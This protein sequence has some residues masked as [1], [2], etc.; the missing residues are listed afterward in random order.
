MNVLSE[1]IC[2]GHSIASDGEYIMI[3]DSD[4]HKLRLYYPSNDSED[5]VLIDELDIEDRPHY[6]QYYK[7]CFFILGSYSG[8]IYEVRVFNGK[9]SLIDTHIIDRSISYARSFSIV[10]N[11]IFIPT[12]DG[13]IYEIDLNSWR[14]K[15]V[16]YVPDDIGGMNFIDRIGDYFYLTV[17]SGKDFDMNC[18]SKILR[19]KKIEDFENNTYEDITNVLSISGTPYFIT[20]FD[21]LYYLTEIDSNQGIIEFS[22]DNQGEIKDVKDIYEYRGERLSSKLRKNRV[23]K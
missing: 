16:Y 9:M 5:I 19:G 18:P 8:S 14:I 1:D 13:R 11:I 2:G 10:D 17:Y 20:Q 4:N 22:I 3:D 7:G 12:A 6:I 21:G 23:F 15:R